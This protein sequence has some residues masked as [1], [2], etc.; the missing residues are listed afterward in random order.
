MPGWADRA[1]RLRR[2]Y[3]GQDDKHAVAL[4]PQ[5]DKAIR[6]FT[7]HGHRLS[8]LY[9]AF[10]SKALT[11]ISGKRIFILPKILHGGLGV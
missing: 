9:R 7:L 10:H 11:L 1:G 6:F 5:G 4:P 2:E 8:S 3:L